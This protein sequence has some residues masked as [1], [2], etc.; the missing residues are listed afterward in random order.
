MAQ[1]HVC[2]KEPGRPVDTSPGTR[3]TDRNTV[4]FP[5]EAESRFSEAD[6]KESS[7]GSDFLQHPPHTT[8]EVTM[9]RPRPAGSSKPPGSSRLYSFLIRVL[10]GEKE[11]NSE[12][13]SGDLGSGYLPFCRR[14]GP[15]G[16]WTQSIGRE[17][18]T[19]LRLSSLSVC[20]GRKRTQIRRTGSTFKSVKVWSIV[21]ESQANQVVFL[22]IFQR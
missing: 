13:E 9:P 1:G 15:R 8:G 19:S 11:N 6:R 10:P 3:L 16:S 18:W 4:R 14:K 20:M 21:N 5:G 22:C 2:S 17:K 12:K 7:H